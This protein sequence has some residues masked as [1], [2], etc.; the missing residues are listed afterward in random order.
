MYRPPSPPLQEPSSLLEK[1]DSVDK[2]HPCGN[3][4]LS[5]MNATV[6]STSVGKFDA[7]NNSLLE[8][9]KELVVDPSCNL[10][11]TRVNVSD[12]KPKEPNLATQSGPIEKSP[13][14][15]APKETL[16]DVGKKVIGKSVSMNCKPEPFPMIGCDE[17]SL[18]PKVPLVPALMGQNRE[19]CHQMP[20]NLYPSLSLSLSKEKCADQ[21]K[22]VDTT[23]INDSVVSANRSNWDLNTTMDAWEGSVG[24]TPPLDTV[25]FHGLNKTGA[26]LDINPSLVSRS[27]LGVSVDS[28]KHI[29]GAGDSRPNFPVS[30]LPPSQFYK[31]EDPLHLSLS[32]SFIRTNFSG[33]HFSSSSD[34]IHAGSSSAN[35]SAG[36][37]A[38]IHSGLSANV[39]SR[40]SA[41]VNLSGAVAYSKLPGQLV[42]TK[43]STAGIN[44]KPEPF[45]GSAKHESGEGKGNSVGSSSI[46]KREV[47]EKCSTNDFNL[48]N[49]IA[50]VV[51]PKPVKSEPTQDSNKETPKLTEATMHGSVGVVLQHQE[52]VFPT[53]GVA[54]MPEKSCSS[55]LPTCSELSNQSE[56]TAKQA[57]ILPV[58]DKS[59]ELNDLDGNVNLCPAEDSNVDEL[60][61]SRGN[62]EALGSDEE[63]VNI[64]TDMMEE[65]SYGSDCE[66]DGKEEGTCGGKEE[67]EYED[68]EVREPVVQ[69]TTVNVPTDEREENSA[70]RG[71]CENSNL[72]SSGL[73][74]NENINQDPVDD[75]KDREE[76]CE[77]H[78]KEC[79]DSGVNDKGD[80]ISDKGVCFQEPLTVEVAAARAEA[81]SPTNATE[82][83]LTETDVL[84]DGGTNGGKGTETETAVG[85]VANENANGNDE[86]EKDDSYL[87]MT[88]AAINGQDSA[89]DTDSGGGSSR[90]RIINLPRASNVVSPTETRSIPD[91]S[92]LSGTGK[93][94]FAD[95]EGEKLH[96]RRNR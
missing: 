82:R 34:N 59:R 25:G 15:L 40:S 16:A 33:E 51:E 95:F 46:I 47:V 30:S 56:H 78:I 89:K 94:R 48:S 76:V 4:G 35:V 71:D 64:S 52:N 74:G 83:R 24:D 43:N 84:S 77:D 93:E 65:D 49:A 58:G 22:S 3:Q 66:S 20:D 54:L 12:T 31:A 53:T 50:K 2:Q 8:V 42:S 73:I 18:G 13:L 91:R 5:L 28:G 67:D 37:S 26:S 9:K 92:F 60:P 23:A 85:E 38:D 45:D 70:N 79:V 88:E 21:T 14:N 96:L 90:S 39:H 72:N 41:N 17:F 68:G 27:E 81:E 10:V 61:H 1:N 6:A 75:D 69:N 57:A 55:G 87:F 19:G 86:R 11:Q 80:Q 32:P 29:L 62:T 7:I 63:K 36:S 44:V